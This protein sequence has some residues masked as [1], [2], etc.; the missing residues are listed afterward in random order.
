MES[1][2]GDPIRD[3]LGVALVVSLCLNVCLFLDFGQ[4]NENAVPVKQETTNMQ[5]SV[6]YNPGTSENGAP[7]QANLESFIKIEPTETP[8]P[9]QTPK[10]A[11]S[12]QTT[13]QYEG[14]TVYITKSGKKFHRETCSSLSKSKIP[15]LYEDACQKNYTACGR[16]KP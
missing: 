10:S 3:L 15:I 5:T 7:L 9:T 12:S 16:C 14:A 1:K 11:P 4:R 13:L 6:L 8:A 2:K